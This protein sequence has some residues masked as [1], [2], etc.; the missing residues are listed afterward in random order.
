MRKKLR[1][2]IIARKNEIKIF[3]PSIKNN[4]KSAKVS[5]PTEIAKGKGLS[6]FFDG[7]VLGAYFSVRVS[8]IAAGI[9]IKIIKNNPIK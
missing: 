5:I 6:L 2:E 1:D 9:I 8:K 4:R 3:C 7:I